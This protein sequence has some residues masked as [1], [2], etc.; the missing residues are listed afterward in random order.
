VSTAL[1]I[2]R[3]GKLTLKD[4]NRLRW[5]AGAPAYADDGVL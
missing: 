5:D 3:V 2:D 4:R 1:E